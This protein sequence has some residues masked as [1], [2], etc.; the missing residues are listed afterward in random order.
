M[1]FRH[2]I[3]V[4]AV[5]LAAAVSA[6]AAERIV[7]GELRLQNIPEIPAAVSEITSRYEHVRSASLLS[8]HPKGEGMLI[9][10]RF[11]ETTQVHHVAR[12]GGARKQITF[13]DEPVAS[14]SYAP[15]ARFDGFLFS[16]DAGGGE[17][18]QIY[19]QETG[20]G[21]ARLLTDGKSVNR[22]ARWSNAGDRFAYVSTR[23]NGRDFD[24]YVAD[25]A[26]D[27]ESRLLLERQG[28]WSPGDWSP[29]DRRL[30]VSRYVSVTESQIEILDLETGELVPFNRPA[31]GADSIAYRSIAWA[32]DGRG[33]FVVSDEGGEFHRLRHWDLDTGRQVVLTPEIPWDVEG[34]TMSRDRSRLAFVVNEG[35]RSALYLMDASTREIRAVDGIPL[36][37]IG[38]VSFSYDGARL[39]FSI[40]TPRTS[41]DVYALVLASGEIERWTESEI[42]GLDAST[43]VEP[44]LVAY[45]TFD[46]ERPGVRREIPA[47][48]YRPDARTAGSRAPVLISIHGGPESQSRPFFSSAFQLYVRELGMAVIVPN[49]RG[50]T[51]YGKTYVGLDNGFLREDSVRD[52]G[53]L[54]DWIAQQSDLDPERV[55]V[56]GGSYGGYMTLAS[57]VHYADRLAGGID[58]VGISNFLTFLANTQDY[59]RDLRRVEYG[60]ERDPEMRAF[61][62]RISPANHVERMTKP[63]LIVQGYNDPRVPVSESEQMVEALQVRGAEPWYLL[64]M[65][66]GHGFRRK[67]NV[68]AMRDIV[69][70]FLQRVTAR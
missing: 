21:S 32:A 18:H 28:S 38:S 31:E 16:R 65:N 69:Y 25:L 68:D 43:F 66:E 56:M 62:E 50:S 4:T 6:P 55:V 57:M 36:G 9:A 40:S 48:I 67:E 20:G 64:A 15:D 45:P 39:G 46:D 11:A 34:F 49:V 30:I 7:R 61:L 70:L 41:G 33:L 22:S 60:D 26:S 14:A 27:G 63:M 51:G 8:W 3:V 53:A 29:D 23:R 19:W 5:A 17:F 1:R 54:L 24:L 47:W 37:V 59:R 35:G 13:Y 44:E 58:I 12:P 2:S 52:I 42:G 10:T